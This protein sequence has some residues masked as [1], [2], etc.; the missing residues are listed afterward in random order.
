MSLWNRRASHNSES[1][2]RGKRKGS[3]L[4]RAVHQRGDERGR[5]SLPWVLG[6]GL[7]IVIFEYYVCKAVRKHYFPPAYRGAGWKQHAAEV[8]D[9]TA[10]DRYRGTSMSQTH[11][12]QSPE[13]CCLQ[14]GGA[15]AVRA[16][17]GSIHTYYTFS[18]KEYTGRFGRFTPLWGTMQTDCSD[19]MLTVCVECCGVKAHV[20]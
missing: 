18:R 16:R 13:P 15:R 20:V 9:K 5:V 8:E 17:C 2:R 12:V 19:I 14:V 7:A 6:I 10:A 4:S 1:S 11:S 3:S